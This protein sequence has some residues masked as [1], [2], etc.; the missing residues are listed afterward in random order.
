MTFWTKMALSFCAEG[1]NWVFFAAE[2]SQKRWKKSLL[3]VLYY[4]FIQ[5]LR[6][7]GAAPSGSRTRKC[8]LLPIILFLKECRFNDHIWLTQSRQQLPSVSRTLLVPPPVV[9]PKSPSLNASPKP[10]THSPLP[11][12]SSQLQQRNQSDSPS[13]PVI[14]AAKP[15]PVKTPNQRIPIKIYSQCL[16]S[17][18]EYKT[19]SVNHQVG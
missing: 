7:R 15:S 12:N 1:K 5:I 16:C 3:W 13:L 4:R 19:L 2:F 10:N 8:S 9:P 18:I 6:G 17:D 14:V 11:K